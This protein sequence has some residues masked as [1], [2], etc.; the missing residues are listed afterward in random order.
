MFALRASG[1]SAT[2]KSPDGRDELLLA[3][4]KGCAMDAGIALL[5][6]LGGEGFDA[7]T[8]PVTDFETLLL[9]LRV[10]RFGP[11]LSLAFTCPRC[12]TVAEIAFR[13][14]DLIEAAQPRR[15]AAVTEDADCPGWYRL[16]EAGFRL[17]TARDQADAAA[18]P[19][20][21]RRLAELCLDAPA[22]AP[23]ARARTE[24]AMEAMA[25]LLSREIDGTCP[26]CEAPVRMFLSIPEIVVREL[27]RAAATV[28]EE[29]DLI[30]RA[31]HWPEADILS[32]PAGRRRAYAEL[33]RRSP[34]RAA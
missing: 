19:R 8:L 27:R 30:A 3:E 13:A 16:A 6:R 24:R 23:R 28:Y 15:P 33:I 18:H 31:Y 22:R 17:P 10:A 9:N 2:L 34:P 32:L 29:I 25:P 5:S 4:A 1:A 12:R 20:P 7:G 11:T 26:G 21:E 14:A